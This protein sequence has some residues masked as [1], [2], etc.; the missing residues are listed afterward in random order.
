MAK[1]VMRS[2]KTRDGIA[3]IL[4]DNLGYMEEDIWERQQQWAAE[5][6][7]FRDMEAALEQGGLRVLN[8]PNM[9]KQN[10]WTYMSV[11]SWTEDGQTY[12][13]PDGDYIYGDAARVT[14]PGPY[15]KSVRSAHGQD[16]DEIT[17]TLQTLSGDDIITE[18]DGESYTRPIA[19]TVT[20]PPE[21]GWGNADQLIF[22][23]GWGSNGDQGLL[24]LEDG[25]EYTMCCWAKVTG[26][27]KMRIRF[28][29]GE[30]RNGYAHSPSKEELGAMTYKWIEISNT[31]WERIS[32]RFTY[33]A[34]QTW[35]E[36]YYRNIA[37][38][39]QDPIWE[40]FQ[41]TYTENYQPR[42]SFGVCRKYAGTVLLCGFR[43]V[44]GRLWISETYDG[45]EDG[46]NANAS[47]IENLKDADGDIM[48]NLAEAEEVTAKVNHVAGEVFV[49][50]NQM[51]R[52]TVAIAAGE[53]IEVGTNCEVKTIEEYFA[54]KQNPNF[55]G[56]V[57]M[58]RRD[59]DYIG[60][61]STG[62]G[63]VVIASGYYSQAMGNWTTAQRK[64]QFVFGEFN[65]PDQSG[66]Y[67]TRGNY[68]E[69]VGNGSMSKRSN[70]RTLDWNGNEVLAGK[71]T[72]GAGPSADMDAATKKYVDD[73]NAGKILIDLPNVN[74]G[75][76]MFQTYTPFEAQKYRI[77]KI[78]IDNRYAISNLKAKTGKDNA[79]R[80]FILIQ[81]TVDQA[82]IYTNP[83]RHIT[84]ELE[85]IHKS[86]NAD[87]SENE[88]NGFE[89]ALD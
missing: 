81:A 69:I 89:T 54:P 60:P 67:G 58:G 79:S 25:K 71:L 88:L 24:D 34:S 48:A 47:A 87:W 70:A 10:Y 11:R 62:L 15:M 59:I 16:T 9:L 14:G 7:K 85:R 64:S 35:Q 50:G 6:Q 23:H 55:T 65:D 20:N 73:E 1:G 22:N 68:V 40:P 19:F 45:L 53:T 4:A 43:L 82:A 26:G 31:V 13:L 32:W 61:S 8:K 2:N 72:V 27:T 52:A 21:Q 30:N 57:S 29:W 17:E 33:H 46:I 3:A 77:T 86:Y 36:T 42:V 75:I 18:M 76:G 51:Y 74:M 37:E 63:N 80:S 66:T 5:Q 41:V 84:L 38:E 78:T 83:Y 39:G 28:G 49:I 56:S 12:T 44:K